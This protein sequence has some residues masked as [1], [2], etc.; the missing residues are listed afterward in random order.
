MNEVARR[1]KSQL[2]GATRRLCAYADRNRVR[3]GGHPALAH[4]ARLQSPAASY[5]ELTQWSKSVMVTGS[6]N[7]AK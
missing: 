3:V 6:A 2:M 1:L 5:K 4:Q 7:M